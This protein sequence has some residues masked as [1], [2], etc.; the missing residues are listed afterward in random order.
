M[1]RYTVRTH[2]ANCTADATCAAPA[3]CSAASQTGLFM[4]TACAAVSIFVMFCL[5]VAVR[6]GL[7]VPVCIPVSVILV[8]IIMMAY[9]IIKK[10]AS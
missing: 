10:D 3:T 2:S 9:M 8:S 6:L 4:D 5:L 7:L 1:T